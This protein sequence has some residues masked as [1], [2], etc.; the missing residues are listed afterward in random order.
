MHSTRSSNTERTLKRRSRKGRALLLSSEER[1]RTLFENAQDCIFLKDRYL[2]YVDLNSAML[3]FLGL[4]AASIRGKTDFDVFEEEYARQAEEVEQRVLGGQTVETEQSITYRSRTMT[5]DFMRF[6]MRDSQGDINGICGIV[7]D[8]T[9]R[10]GPTAGAGEG[11]QEYNSQAMRSTIE[12][13]C[14]VART[15]STVLLTGESG[16]GKDY[17]ARYIHDH[18]KRSGG[19]FLAIN[20]AAVAHDLAESELFGHEEGA[21]TGAGRRKRGLVE[22]AEGGTLLL[23]EI[24]ELSLTLQS[25]LLSFLD[26]HT[27]TRVGGEQ[28][29]TV[30]ARIIAATN[31]NLALE[32]QQG[33]FRQDLFYRLNVFAV[34]VPPLRDRVDDIP[35]LIKTLVAKIK[36][37][38]QLP[39]EPEFD[40]SAIS[41]LCSYSWP[42]NVR[43][44]R[45]VLERALILCRGRLIRSTH[46]VLDDTDCLPLPVVDGA[47]SNQTLQGALEALKRS[48]ILDA[49][50]K[51]GGKKHEAAVMLGIN[52]FKLTREL[53]RLNIFEQ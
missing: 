1:F 28:S 23:N 21:F 14:L 9:G 53:I 5:L 29:I 26:T 24:G 17:L 6:P 4:P 32:A 8:M 2:K 19:R 43:E 20:C 51:S 49:L 27:L 30:N 18:S 52:R 47:G 31:R 13:A 50:K 46:L 45:N 41:R 3:E 11:V 12:N 38:M 15:D 39:T 33:G 48:M 25:K 7:R 40:S 35:G 10:L 36:T 44:L 22:L 37:E 16:S 42:G 34:K